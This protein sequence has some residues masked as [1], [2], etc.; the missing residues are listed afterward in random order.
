MRFFNRNHS[1]PADSSPFAILTE[2]LKM[3]AAALTVRGTCG[4][5]LPAMKNG[6][7]P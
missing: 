6:V 3:R 5:H 7:C 1:F 2:T 4:S